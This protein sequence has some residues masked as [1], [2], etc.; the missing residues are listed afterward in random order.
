MLTKN[1]LAVESTKIWVYNIKVGNGNGKILFAKKKCIVDCDIC[2]SATVVTCKKGKPFK[3]QRESPPILLKFAPDY[4]TAG[5]F[6][7][8]GTEFHNTRVFIRS[9]MSFYIVLNIF[10]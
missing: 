4:F 10:F 3:F 1:G 8:F 7:K 2:F 9:G 5:G 6:G